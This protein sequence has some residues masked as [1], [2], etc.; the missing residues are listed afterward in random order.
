MGALGLLPGGSTSRGHRLLKNVHARLDRAC[1]L[2]PA[3]K[4]SSLSTATSA[5]LSNGFPRQASFQFTPQ[6]RVPG[7]L[8]T[9]PPSV[10]QHWQSRRGYRGGCGERTE[11]TLALS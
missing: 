10:P 3:A 5:R 6:P 2:L 7:L 11:R 4:L 9:G 8:R 1:L